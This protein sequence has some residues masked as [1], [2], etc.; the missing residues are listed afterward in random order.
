[1]PP[2]ASQVQMMNERSAAAGQPV[3]EKLRQA[4]DLEHWPA[5][6]ASFDRLARL[7]ERVGSRRR[8]PRR[9]SACSPGT[10]TTATPRAPAFRTPTRSR[11]Y[12]LTCSPVRNGVPWF[13]EY[14]FATGWM[15]P[16]VGAVRRLGRWWGVPEE[17]V[18]WDPIGG[19]WFGNA[20]ATLEV[21]GRPPACAG[22]A[23]GRTARWTGS[24][25]C[26]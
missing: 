3:A 11:V 24:R 15:R 25:T 1:M 13:M 18:T 10:C 21:T 22:S 2:A 20:V 9:R 26:R 7:I 16:V 8:R 4:V 23:P 12:Q 17:P 14:V 19:P 5:F 6:R